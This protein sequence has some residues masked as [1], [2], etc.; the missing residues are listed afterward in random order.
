MEIS[1]QRAT[2]QDAAEIHAMQL[3]AFKSLLE[4]YQ[5]LDTNPGNEDIHKVIA[6]IKQVYTDYYIIKADDTSVGA[7]RI[8]RL[9]DGDRC[10]ISPIFILP[11]YQ[12]LGIAQQVFTEMER[13]YQPVSG[14]ELETVLEESRN[15]YLYEKLGYS[16]TGRLQRINDR[17]TLV[18]YEK[19]GS[20][21]RA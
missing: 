3:C 13:R 14:W 20:A 9:D 18:F 2:L 7:I 12:G 11:P 10:R 15:C 6:R 4:K 21:G 8:V 1:L 5:D 17:M 19:P 16:K